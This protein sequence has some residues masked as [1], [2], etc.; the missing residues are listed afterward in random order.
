MLV[1][2]A[3]EMRKAYALWHIWGHI[4]CFCGIVFDFDTRGCVWH[5]IVP[6]L[7][8][9]NIVPVAQILNPKLGEFV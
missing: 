3:S 7:P 5:E 2:V 9:D 1:L 6:I 4:V 8:G